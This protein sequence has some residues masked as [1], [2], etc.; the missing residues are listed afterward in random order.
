MPARNCRALHVACL[1]SPLLAA[2]PAAA[3]SDI[4][5]ITLTV[6]NQGAAFDNRGNTTTGWTGYLITATADDPNEAIGYF[7]IGDHTDPSF[8]VFGSLLQDWPPAVGSTPVRSSLSATNGSPTGTDT[9][10]LSLPTYLVFDASEDSDLTQPAGAPPNQPTELWGTGTA[11]H[12]DVSIPSN[13]QHNSQPLAYVVTKDGTTASFHI[14]VDDKDRRN[15]RFFGSFNTAGVTTPMVEVVA[16]PSS[17]GFPGGMGTIILD[18]HNPF[19]CDTATFNPV[20]SINTTIA[21]DIRPNGGKAFATNINGG[22][23]AATDYINV[24]HFQ[25]NLPE[26]FAVNLKIGGADPTPGQLQQLIGDINADNI[27]DVVAQPADPQLFP[28]YDL[29]MTVPYVDDRDGT[30]DWFAFDFTKDANVPGVIVTDIAAAQGV[31]EPGCLALVGCCAMLLP[32]RRRR[33]AW[34]PD[35]C[36][37]TGSFARP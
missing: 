5:N 11:L 22:A 23:G 1:V 27:G 24:T 21:L 17:A 10:L 7:I 36:R 8:G 37:T 34:P 20:P 16:A 4:P 9:H 32:S 25:K 30:G 29:M 26:L 12:G 31:P 15:Y 2:M 13:D 14:E 6:T 19:H 3:I 28:G 18:T 35:C 33:A